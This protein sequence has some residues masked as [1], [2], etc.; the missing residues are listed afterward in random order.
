[1]ATIAVTDTGTQ[2]P[3]VALSTAQVGN[4]DSTNIIDRGVIRSG[5]LLQIVSTIG[6]TPTVTLAVLGSMDGTNFWNVPYALAA[7]PETVAVAAL[8]ITTAVTG[9]YILREGHP[10]RYLK[11]NATANTNVTLTTTYFSSGG[12]QF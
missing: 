11:T 9:F 1:M 8:V 12:R 2:V 5:G 10:W 7:T 4:G 3:N 6:A